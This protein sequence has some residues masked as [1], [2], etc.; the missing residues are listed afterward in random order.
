MNTSTIQDTPATHSAIDLIVGAPAAARAAFVSESSLYAA[1][2]RDEFV[3]PVKLG[4]KRSAW[5][6]NEIAAI[7]AAH[8]RGDTIEAIKALV[9]RLVEARKSFGLEVAK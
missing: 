8:V 2:Q 9:V 5:P 6:A 7:V 1:I 4:R 3:P